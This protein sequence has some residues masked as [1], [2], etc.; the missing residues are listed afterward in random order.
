[1]EQGQKQLPTLMSVEMVAYECSVSKNTIR[2]WMSEKRFPSVKLS[3]R[4]LIKSSDLA[5]IIDLG[6]KSR[7]FNSL[8]TTGRSGLD[9]PEDFE[10]VKGLSAKAVPASVKTFQRSL[11]NIF[12][13]KMK[14]GR[15]V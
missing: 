4:V 12:K 7:L 9:P 1:M 2:R 3:S 5:R 8:I 13:I 11:N 15:V 14:R 6:L 10:K